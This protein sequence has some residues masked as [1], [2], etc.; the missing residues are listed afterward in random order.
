MMTLKM[1]QDL[2][3]LCEEYSKLIMIDMGSYMKR[4][5]KIYTLVNKRQDTIITRIDFRVAI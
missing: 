5:M 2:W 1:I 4:I 3:N